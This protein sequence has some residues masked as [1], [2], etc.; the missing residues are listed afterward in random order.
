ML[1]HYSP[2]KVAETFS[3]LSRLYP[4]RIELGIGRAPGTD[5]IMMHA[6]Q[7]DRRHAIPDDFPE[8]LVELLAYPEDRLPRDHPFAGLAA[9][10]GLPE[11]PDPG[12][13]GSS[14]QSAIWAAELGLRY[15]FADFINPRGRRSPPTTAG[16]PTSS[17]PR[18]S[19]SRLSPSEHCN[20]RCRPDRNRGFVQGFSTPARLR[21]RPSEEV[22]QC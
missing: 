5:M 4:E 16:A 2:L 14:A 9:L 17:S 1:P 21:G 3:I 10:S 13:L 19:G 18:R 22:L 20:G 8:Q 6:L 11:R 15:A 12:L 7:R